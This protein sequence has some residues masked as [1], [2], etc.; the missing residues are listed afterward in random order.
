VFDVIHAKKHGSTNPEEQE[1]KTFRMQ[2]TGKNEA[3]FKNAPGG[4]DLILKRKVD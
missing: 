4:G 3:V 1:I 2:L